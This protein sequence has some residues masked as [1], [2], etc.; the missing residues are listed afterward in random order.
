MIGI[1]MYSVDIEGDT[2]RYGIRTISFNSDER[3][4]QLNGRTVPLNGVSTPPTLH[5]MHLTIASASTLHG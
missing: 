4:F 1:F 5:Q 3:R 2:Y